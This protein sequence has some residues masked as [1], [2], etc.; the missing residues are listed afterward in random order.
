MMSMRSSRNEPPSRRGH[1]SE[2]P[3]L[4]GDRVPGEWVPGWLVRRWRSIDVRLAGI[5]LS[6][7]ALVAFL[8]ALAFYS[9]WR[10][11]DSTPSGSSIDAPAA[12]VEQ[13]GPD[14]ML[15]DDVSAI[16]TH[17]EF[18]A[19]DPVELTEGPWRFFLTSAEE[20]AMYDLLFFDDGTFHETGATHNAGTYREWPDVTMSLTRVGT[21]EASDGVNTRTEEISWSETSILVRTGDTMTGVWE[22]ESWQFSYDDGMSAWG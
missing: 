6:A 18:A 20:S 9:E 5:I 21:G 1:V 11:D 10:S 3:A 17:A 16:P 19:Q 7:I 14:V 13:S 15:A 12:V 2:E 4:E 22:R 8:I